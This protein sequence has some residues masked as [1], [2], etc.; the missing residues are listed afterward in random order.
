M[1]EIYMKHA[2]FGNEHCDESEQAAREAAGWVR[3][4]RTQEQKKV[5][6]PSGPDVPSET[7]PR[8][9]SRDELE[10]TAQLLEMKVD[11]RWSNARLAEEIA[12]VEAE[13]NE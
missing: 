2:K 9:Q 5:G 11:G 3:W 10:E 7:K 4:P 1:P 12:K 8:K 13:L 6:V